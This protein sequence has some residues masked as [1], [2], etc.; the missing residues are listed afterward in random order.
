[1]LKRIFLSDNEVLRR[2]K[3]NDRTVLGELYISNERIISSY[4]KNHGGGAADIAD[5]LQEAIIV[6]W[7]NVN[8]GRFELSAKISTYLFAIA[9]NKWMAEKRRQK[10]L[11]HNIES[12]ENKTDGNN[13]LDNLIDDEQKLLVRE[14]L[15]KLEPPCKELLLLFYFE[16]RSMNEIA[17]IL[18]FANSNVAK[19][20]KYQCKKALEVLI[21]S[22]EKK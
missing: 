18:N 2:I 8:A 9:K 19:A 17:E 20:K 1:M 16:E 11:D 7:Q 12:L 22:I 4:I 3:A 21:K 5:L 13:S 6:L 14:A 15:Q 10:K